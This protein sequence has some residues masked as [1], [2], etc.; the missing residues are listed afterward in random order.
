MAC[1]PINVLRT[2]RRVKKQNSDPTLRIPAG[3]FAIKP[4]DW[5]DH[6]SAYSPRRRNN[7]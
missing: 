1:S 4:P 7:S 5:W 3:Y 6:K 2:D